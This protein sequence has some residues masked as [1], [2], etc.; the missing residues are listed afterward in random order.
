MR[1]VE[2]R[3]V[4]TRE[5]PAPAPQV[6]VNTP[7]QVNVNAAPPAPV[8]V[9]DDTGD[10][11]GAAA[12]NFMTVLVILGVIV[13][14][15]IGAYYYFSANPIIINTPAPPAPQ[16]NINPPPAQ[17]PPAQQPPVQQPPAQQR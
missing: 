1:E 11:T 12:I 7:P 4:D 2:T 13:A 10:R 8:V 5:T 9:A 14:L 17:Q 16:I 15:A 3:E 6:N